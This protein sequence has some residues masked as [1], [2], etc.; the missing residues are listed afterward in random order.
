MWQHPAGHPP[1]AVTAL[2]GHQAITTLPQGPSSQLPRPSSVVLLPRTAE[3]SRD[4]A[5]SVPTGLTAPSFCA[6]GFNTL[7][8]AKEEGQ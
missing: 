5:A 8:N 6:C 1:V 2:T 4:L 3:M 7:T